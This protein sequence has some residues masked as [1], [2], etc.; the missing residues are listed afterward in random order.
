METNGTFDEWI[1]AYAEVPTTNDVLS[2]TFN[3]RA[4]ADYLQ[5]VRLRLALYDPITYEE[6]FYSAGITGSDVYDSGFLYFNKTFLLEVLSRMLL[7][8]SFTEVVSW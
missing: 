4:K 6:I 3:G 5:A 1:G 7:T 8:T 2:L